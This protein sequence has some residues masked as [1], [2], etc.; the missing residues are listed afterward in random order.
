MRRQGPVGHVDADAFY[1]AAERVRY[2]HLAGMP[3]GVLGNQ[4]ACVI[5]KSYEMKA[6]GVGT[7][8]PIWDAMKLCPEGIYVK[9]D[10]RW[11]E[12]LSRLMLETMRELSPRVEYY[13][14]DE[15]FFEAAKPP[16]GD[17]QDYAVLVRDRL[18]DRI[19]VPVTVG[20]ARTRTLAKLISDTAKPFGALAILDKAAE[21]SL[22]AARPVTDVTGIAGRREKRLLPWGIRTCLDLAKSDRR[23]IRGLL[24]ASGEALWWE[25]NGDPVIPINA[26]RTPHKVISRG[27]SFGDPTDKPDVLWA[28]LVRNLERM[29][30]ELLYHRVLAGRV[31][32]WVGY[33]D[34]HAGEG[35]ATLEVPTDRFDVLLDTF[36]PCLRRAWVPRALASRMHLF[37]EDLRPHTPRQ[38][39]LFDG[40]D[41]EDAATAVKQAVNDRHG[42]F[43]LRSVATLPLGQVYADRANG[44]DICDVRG[45]TC[46]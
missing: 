8:M 12:V 22:L 9:R 5:A 7:G 39:G 24:T 14:I 29:V 28:W 20:I 38:L 37:A 3:V 16:A 43:A 40:L 36:R 26:E 42:R 34:G 19:R 10:F 32:V 4:G 41:A 27:G 44:Y 17:Y 31:A 23:L 25:L 2:A 33:R 35:R 18:M 21:E 15:F 30:E 6:T 45:K 13:S 1:V 46:F 11:Y